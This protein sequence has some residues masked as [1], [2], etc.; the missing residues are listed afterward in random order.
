MKLTILISALAVA[1]SVAADEVT[2]TN[3]PATITVNISTNVVSGDNSSGCNICQFDI[4]GNQLS[5]P[6]TWPP[7]VCSPFKPAT[8]RWTTTNVVQRTTIATVWNGKPLTYSEETTLSSV[9]G[10][11]KL[12]SEWKK[13][14]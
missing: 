13:D 7:S 6:A 10:R 11:W 3:L 9:T 4:H 8:E 14:E 12:A 5:H 2:K 1:V